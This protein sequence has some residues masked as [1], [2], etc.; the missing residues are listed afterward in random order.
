MTVGIEQC[1][2][3]QPIAVIIE[4]LHWADDTT[5]RLFAF[6]ARRI[7]DVPLLLVAT[8]RGDEIAGAL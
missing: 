1:A 4:D 7:R 5:L 8:A 6:V 3:R 2:S